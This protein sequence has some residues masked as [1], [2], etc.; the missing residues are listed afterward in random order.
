M[1]DARIHTSCGA[2]KQ[3]ILQSRKVVGLRR[4]SHRARCKRGAERPM[5]GREMSQ[6]QGSTCTD[7][8][9]QNTRK[10]VGAQQV[11]G[12]WQEQ[13]IGVDSGE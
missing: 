7:R 12:G 5:Q 13:G 11:D 3:I 9:K 2:Q 8:L 4:G 1:R 6:R 10:T